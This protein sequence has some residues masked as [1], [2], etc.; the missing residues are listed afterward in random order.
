MSQN[1]YILFYSSKCIHCKEFMTMLHKDVNLN[2][3]FLKVNVDNSSIKLPPY[4]KV[5]P[6]V[7]I[8]ANGK[9]NLLEGTQ[10]F[11]W[12]NDTHQKEVQN[13]NIME[14]DP[15]SMSGYSDNFSYIDNNEMM[16]K[17]FSEINE[18]I[19]ISTPDDTQYSGE[20]KKKDSAKNEFDSNYE[21]FMNQRKV[22]VPS[23]VSRM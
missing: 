11:K 21:Q 13:Q 8:T 19:K 3:K 20:G 2:E 18:D 7:I 4:V 10:I 12:F 22:E 6:T 1:D 5:V 15:L 23:G 9:P 16:K 14:W 17:S